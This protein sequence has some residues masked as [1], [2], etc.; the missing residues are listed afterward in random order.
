MSETETDPIAERLLKLLDEIDAKKVTVRSFEN[1]KDTVLAFESFNL[2]LATAHDL[3][4]Y[5][6]TDLTSCG[7]KH[8]REYPHIKSDEQ[9]KEKENQTTQA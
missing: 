9:G 7:N 1:S 4:G 5:A 8:T 2:G 3:V 6:Y